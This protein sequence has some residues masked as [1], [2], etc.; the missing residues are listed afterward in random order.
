MPKRSDISKVLVLGAGPIR[1]GQACEFDYSGTQA[2]KALKDEGY[3]VVLVNSNPATIMTDPGRATKTYIE[4]LTAAV[5]KQI[6]EIERPD[7][8]LPT[9]G[10]QTALNVAVE[11][12]LSG[13]L[14]TLG[15]ELIGAS[16][17]S[18]E[19]AE[20]R[21]LFKAKMLEIGMPLPKSA[22]IHSLEEIGQIAQELGFPVIVRPAF[23]LGGSG[24][25][26]AHSEAEL[27]KVC[28][29]GLQASPVSKVLLEESIVGWKEL[30]FE[31][32]RDKADN[33]IVVC[34]IENIDPM[35]I[36][37]G[38]SITVA[39]VQTLS[40]PEFQV[41]R[42]AS[43]KIIRAVGI[44]CGGSNIQFAINPVNGQ[45]VVIEMNP[46]VSRSSALA[47]KATGYP[48]AKVAAKLAIGLTL[49]EIRNDIV[50]DVSACF[51]PVLDYVVTKLPRFE[52]GKFSGSC[53]ILGTQM[54]SV[55]EAMGIGSTFQES[56]QKAFRSLELGVNGFAQLP[57]RTSIDRSVWEKRMTERSRFRLMDVW[58]AFA[59]GLSIDE[60]VTLSGFDAWFLE[61][62]QEIFIIDRRLSELVRTSTGHI[63]TLLSKEELITLKQMGFGDAQIAKLFSE[64]GATVSEDVVYELR[65]SLDVFPTY[66]KV[67]TCASE[68]PTTSNYL[69]SSYGA[70][71]SEDVISAPGSEKVIILGSGPNRIGQGIEFD[72][73]C[74]QASLCLKDRGLTP[75]MVNCNPETVST[76]YD[77]SSKL[78]FEPI[79]LEDVSNIVLRE[80]NP[81]IIIQMGGQTPLKLASA[82]EARGFKLL[83]TSVESINLAECRDAFIGLLKRLGLKRPAGAVAYSVQEATSVAA[84]I[85][86]PVLIRPSYVLGG[87]AM[88]VVH[89]ADQL[90]K[91][92]SA[93]FAAA[94]GV[95][96]DRFLID[97]IEVDVDAISDG[98]DTVICGVMEHVEQAGVH[99][100]DSSCFMPPQ[101]LN[102]QL[103]DQMTLITKAIAAELSVKG[104]LNIQFA[105]QDG[106]VYVL[107]ANP[108][109]SRTVP[110]VSK[111]SGIPWASIGT[112]VILG[113]S[114]PSL[115]H[116]WQDRVACIAVKSAVLPFDKF[117]QSVIA[118]GPEMRSTGEVMG[119][120]QD[121]CCA[122]SKAQNGANRETR[123][124]KAVIVSATADCLSHA[125]DLLSQYAALGLK[126]FITDTLSNSLFAPHL[127]VLDTSTMEITRE[128][129]QA[130]GIDL[131]VS[132]S[133]ID[134]FDAREQNLRRAGIDL[135]IVVTISVAEA[136]QIG[137][138]INCGKIHNAPPVSLQD[139]HLQGALS[140]IPPA[141]NLA[142]T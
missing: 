106:E 93:G 142:A 98:H 50:G 17:Q 63:S 13:C 66:R 96:I 18:I 81:G 91:F 111:A 123:G 26:I 102:A 120:A 32:V 72:Y 77:V 36:H 88:Q 86:Y 90:Q 113:E 95:L 59:A 7:A 42:E 76:D 108:R 11:L 92:L 104:F 15:V 127:N 52:F 56:L 3:E 12:A 21:E 128:G 25:G 85:G 112:R 117:R 2:C 129:L 22:V 38:D 37:T 125:A 75:I 44:D 141:K 140:F 71:E 78:Y 57:G 114:V 80:G 34:S 5:V 119:I 60:I 131:I 55:G 79:T 82:L 89:N 135:G 94:A 109:A 23:T 54:K 33:F 29:D 43:K 24:S 48:I 130:Q 30:E 64:H 115:S 53:E 100:G 47:S 139:L 133:L 107:E 116:L 28:A 132:L 41:L 6:I 14:E 58:G 51:E 16:L 20:D 62:L 136:K 19:I 4:P 126:L 9:V 84:T 110:F 87:R 97:A 70:D 40:D 45:F 118:L 73:C 101:N 1:I 124:T 105:I 69:Y 99:S 68:F 8:L 121:A 65:I 83:G 67:D 49:D 103:I 138:S 10:G 61:N 35:G 122:F 31:V 27:L 74:V 137:I 46:R 134:A 39:P